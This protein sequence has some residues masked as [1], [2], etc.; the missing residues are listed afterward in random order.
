M[1]LAKLLVEKHTSLAKIVLPVSVLFG[2]AYTLR[3]DATPY[4]DAADSL[5]EFL[6]LPGSELHARKYIVG[7]RCLP[8]SGSL[9][10]PGRTFCL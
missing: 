4:E 5:S 8:S 6:S 2:F 10:F 1:G 3:N 7:F 9:S